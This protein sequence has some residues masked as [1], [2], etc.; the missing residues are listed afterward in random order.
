MS[1]LLVGSLTH[2]LYKPT[3]NGAVSK[4][5]YIAN[6]TASN[7]RIAIIAADNLPIGDTKA[8]DIGNNNKTILQDTEFNMLSVCL[9]PNNIISCVGATSAVM[10]RNL[11]GLYTVEINGFPVVEVGTPQTLISAL[12][13]NPFVSGLGI[14]IVALPKRVETES[15]VYVFMLEPSE[16]LLNARI[17]LKYAS[18]SRDVVNV[19]PSQLGSYTTDEVAASLSTLQTNPTVGISSSEITFCLESAEPQSYC[20]LFT[21]NDTLGVRVNGEIDAQLTLPV[22]PNFA[23]YDV[24]K[25]SVTINGKL[26]AITYEQNMSEGDTPTLNIYWEMKT[27]DRTYRWDVEGTV[28]GSNVGWRRVESLRET[29]KFVF[30]YDGFYIEGRPALYVTNPK[31]ELGQPVKSITDPTGALVQVEETL[32]SSLLKCVSVLGYA[33]FVP[34]SY[35]EP[36]IDTD[37]VHQDAIDTGVI[38]AAELRAESQESQVVNGGKNYQFTFPYSVDP[39]EDAYL[40]QLDAEAINN[41]TLPLDTVILQGQRTATPRTPLN[42]SGRMMMMG[43]ANVVE[44]NLGEWTLGDIRR[45]A[46]MVQGHM[47]LPVKIDSTSTSL[48]DVYTIDYDGKLAHNYVE[49]IYTVNVTVNMRDSIR[50]FD[51]ICT[52]AQDDISFEVD[53]SKLYYISL[54]GANPPVATQG[55]D[56][57]Q[58]LMEQSSDLL[59]YFAEDVPPPGTAEIECVP[60]DSNYFYSNAIHTATNQGVLLKYQIDDQEPRVFKL[61]TGVA[62]N[63]ANSNNFLAEFIKGVNAGTIGQDS[64]IKIRTVTNDLTTGAYSTNNVL[65]YNFLINNNKGDHLILP[66]GTPHATINGVAATQATE[67]AHVI[68]FMKYTDPVH[69]GVNVTAVG[70]NGVVDIYPILFPGLSQIEIHSCGVE[71]ALATINCTGAHNVLGPIDVSGN[72]NISNGVDLGTEATTIEEI[73][74][75][76]RNLGLEVHLIDKE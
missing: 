23:S 32:I 66:Y 61:G 68:R 20:H 56:L 11:T 33:T 64:N 48:M 76:L 73:A 27:D 36:V 1:T 58:V 29:D 72:F 35:T 26:A 65:S 4:Y 24:D 37:L 41:S 3:S 51:L 19:V 25:Y 52:G 70:G 49:G 59:A 57:P 47:V 38:D 69:E 46:R 63:L 10:L 45:D 8:M 34:W 2:A 43:A 14:R 60:S 53:P 6:N 18:D 44:T 30:C 55:I 15:E 67:N 71:S 21:N 5:L 50:P 75:E 28:A 7:K 16:E 42:I 13:T 54:D 9:T 17:R 39:L 74:E 31:Y 12:S 22:F 62:A 40:L